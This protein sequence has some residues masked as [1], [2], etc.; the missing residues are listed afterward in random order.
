MV[1]KPMG[2]ASGLGAL[3]KLMR[4]PAVRAI[5][6]RNDYAFRKPSY[7]KKGYK[8]SVGYAKTRRRKYKRKR[9][10]M[11]KV[12][13]DIKRLKRDSRAALGDMTV[14]R[15]ASDTLTT[16][17]GAQTVA[18]LVAPNAT[19]VLE[20][21]VLNNLKY[22]DPVTNALVVAPGAA[23]TY[24]RNIRVESTTATVTM[25][26]NYATS[27]HAKLYLCYTKDDTSIDP[28]TAW[29]GGIVD[30][31]NL[32]G[33]ADIGSYPTDFD[34]AKDLYSWKVVKDVLLKP[35]QKLTA[36]HSCKGFEYSP[37]TVDQHALIY[38][39]EYKSF[40]FVLVLRGEL[41]HDTVITNEQLAV[42]GGVDW[43]YKT[44]YKVR[45]NAGKNISF[46]HVDNNLGTAFT[47]SGVMSQK[48]IT[49]NQAY[50]RV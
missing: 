36:T 44:V 4:N 11:T 32:S 47:N 39:K 35:G 41:G 16:G 1:Y 13:R 37:S 31:S 21:N 20:N 34:L 23:G 48:P 14:R 29:G 30:G 25:V 10:T 15:F 9:G 45:Y 49:A 7:K 46:V 2:T 6:R 22:F 28:V 19:T 5:G 24:Q 38:Q 27:L 26:N 50:S 33:L 8:R 18:M 12:K 17:A 3:F 42:P 40:A 43:M